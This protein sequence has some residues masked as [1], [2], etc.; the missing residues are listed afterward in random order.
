MEISNGKNPVG[1]VRGE[2]QSI[3]D[4]PKVDR[5]NITVGTLVKCLRQNY[6]VPGPARSFAVI[7]E[8]REFFGQ[9]M[10]IAERF[11]Q[12]PSEAIGAK[13]VFYTGV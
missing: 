5:K 11:Y 3:D 6:I 4:L 1:L 9:T 8:V 12:S 13:S 10:Y 2:V 7:S